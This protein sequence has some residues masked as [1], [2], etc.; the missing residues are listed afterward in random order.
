MREAFPEYPERKFMIF[1][2]DTG[3]PDLPTDAVVVIGSGAAGIALTQRLNSAGRAQ[4]AFCALHRPVRRTPPFRLAR[5][6]HVD[7]F[8]LVYVA[9][10]RER[11]LLQLA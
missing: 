6:C 3:L 4:R 5:R 7:L 10:D 1:D 9:L 8:Q 2:L 11:P